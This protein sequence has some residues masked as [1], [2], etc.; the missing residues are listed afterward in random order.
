[1]DLSK[2]NPAHLFL[3]LFRGSSG[4]LSIKS[5]L[6]MMLLLVS[7]FSTLFTAVLG[8]K[9]GQINLTDRV[10]NQLT[11]VRASKASQIEAYFRHI[12]NHTLTLSE[13][14]SIVAAV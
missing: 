5:K 9:S 10:Y 4:Q 11:S 8:Y 2:V 7:G 6:I 1:M 14:L 3:Q 13:D 12:Q